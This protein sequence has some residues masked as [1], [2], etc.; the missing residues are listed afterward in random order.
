LLYIDTD[1]V[2]YNMGFLTGKRYHY[3]KTS[4]DQRYRPQGPST[5]LRAMLIKEMIEAGVDSFDFPGEPYEWEEQWTSEMRWHR[6]IVLYN[7]TAK[8]TLFRWLSAMRR[9]VRG[10]QP[11][12]QLKW[13]NP[14][15]LKRSGA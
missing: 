14:K 8:A 9:A 10:R 15:E 3:L 13:C 7:R 5:F 11:E 4:Y 2:A 12:K 6:T 1:P